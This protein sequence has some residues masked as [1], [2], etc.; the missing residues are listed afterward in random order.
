MIPEHI[1]FAQA[2]D[3]YIESKDNLLSPSTVRGYRTQQRNCFDGINDLYITEINEKIVQRWINSLAPTYSAK[4]I[5]N[6]VGLLTVAL[7]QNGITLNM[8]TVTLKPMVK[9][10][11]VIPTEQEI[12]QIA[13]A[14]KNTTVEIPVIIAMTLGL[15]QSEIAGLKWEDYDG[16]FLSVNTAVVPNEHNKMVEKIEMKSY[17]SKRTLPV[18]DYLKKILDSSYRFND[19]VSPHRSGYILKHFHRICEENGMYKFTMHS[20]RHA[21]ASAMLKLNVPDKYAME[22]MGHS[23]PSMLKQVYQHIY[24]DEQMRIAGIINDYYNEILDFFE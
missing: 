14:V 11:Y 10:K 7:G 20:L 19:R 17:A 2:L 22:R 18:P 4:S 15:R 6:N 16:H 12:K 13:V 9:V 21:N 24:T 3:E 23:T 1:T 5:K 8:R